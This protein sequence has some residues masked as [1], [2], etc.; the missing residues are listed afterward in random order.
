MGG[1]TSLAKGSERAWIS[2]VQGKGRVK[3]PRW[4]AQSNPPMSFG[5]REDDEKGPF[6]D[7]GLLREDEGSEVRQGYHGDPWQRWHAWEAWS[8]DGWSQHSWRTPEYDPPE[9]WDRSNDIFIPEFLA[10]FLLLHRAGLDSQEGQS[11]SCHP[12]TVQHRDSGASLA[13]TVV[14]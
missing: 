5:S 2:G 10:G 8:G 4:S 14:R 3:V 6:G 13:R 11:A 1:L 7:D 12:W 9:D